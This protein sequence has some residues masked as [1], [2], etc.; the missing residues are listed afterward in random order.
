[1]RPRHK[2]ARG[3]INFAYIQTRKFGIH[4][5]RD[6]QPVGLDFHGLRLRVKQ[7]VYRSLDFA[8]DVHAGFNPRDKDFTRYV[9]GVFAVAARHA[10]VHAFAVCFGDGEHSA[11]KRRV[12]LG[13]GFHDLDSR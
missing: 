10:N 7:I 4:K 5:L 9:R 13:V 6:G 3:R 12:A 2:L 11:H 8:D 1:M